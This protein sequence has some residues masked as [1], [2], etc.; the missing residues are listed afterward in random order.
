MLG[1]ATIELESATVSEMGLIGV[2]GSIPFWSPDG[3]H[4]VYQRTEDEKP[5]LYVA[6]IDGNDIYRLTDDPAPEW[7]AGWS[8][9]PSF[10]Y[11]G[12]MEEN[13]D[14]NV[15]RIAMDDTGRPKSDPELWMAY[16][17]STRLQQ[18]LDF[19]NDRAVGAIWES[20]SDICLIEFEKTSSR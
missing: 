20:G 12:R 2:T 18:F 4:L 16:T 9:N 11:Y 13:G 17:Q 1:V 19:Q 14:K 10:V 3:G 6:T 15:Y 8:S 5:D 7:L